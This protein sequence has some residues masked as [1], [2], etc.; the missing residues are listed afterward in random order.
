MSF[1]LNVYKL[2]DNVVFWGH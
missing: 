2:P 1:E